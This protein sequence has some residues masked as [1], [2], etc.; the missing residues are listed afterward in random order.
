[1]SEFKLISPMLDNFAMGDSISE[2]DGVCCCP[3]M[4]N[5]SDKRYIVK[6]VSTPASQSQLEALLLSGAYADNDAANE[7]F[8]AITDGIAEEAQILEKLSQ[9]EGFLPF[10]SWQ[11]VPKE[12]GTGYDLYLLSQ[13][14]RTLQ[15]HFKRSGMT[16]L[17]ALNLGLDLCAALAVCRRLGYLYVDLKPENIYLT[18]DN[19]YRI[20]DLGFIK[21]DSLKYASLPDRYR[22]AYT[23]PEITDAFSALNTTMDTYALGL[24]LYQAFNDSSLPLMSK[25]SDA[26][27][28]PS[29]AYADYEMSEIILKA[30]AQDPENRWQDP[31]QMG[32]ALI[33]YM[34]RNGAHD[35]PII[36]QATAEETDCVED[37][38]LFEGSTDMGSIAISDENVA[39]V[40]NTEILVTEDDIYTQD[41]DGN[42]TF[43]THDSDDETAPDDNDVVEDYEQVT[44]EVNKMLNHADELIAH[45]APDPVIQPDPIEVALPES[46]DEENSD[47]DT[48]ADGDEP[49]SESGDESAIEQ[50]DEDCAPDNTEEEEKSVSECEDQQDDVDEDVPATD[51]EVG[52]GDADHEIDEAETNKKKHTAKIWTR[53]IL[54]IVL[55][56][57][58]I[59]AGIFFYMNYYLQPIE[60]IVLQDVEHGTLTVC[61]TSDIDESKLSVVCLDMYGN[62]LTAPV[63]D[64]KAVFTGLAPNSA[65][66]VKININGF[67][68]LTGDTWTSF[69]TPEETN[70]VQFQAVTGAE[71]G[72]VIL[73]FTVEGP[74]ANQWSVRYAAPNEEEKEVAF[75][76]HIATINGLTVGNEYTFTLVPGT[77]L[78]LVGTS[79]ITHTASNVIKAEGL[80]ITGCIDGKLTAKWSAPNDATVDSWTVRCY[81]DKNYDQT[82]VV[83]QPSATFEGV[84]ASVDHTVEVTA[85]AMSISERAFA[86]A[87]AITVTQFTLD[88]AN[89]N[90]LS[91]AWTA[92]AE[93]NWNLLCSIN[94]AVNQEISC[95]TETKASIRDIIPGSQ[96]K[97]T[98][99]ATDGTPVLGGEMVYQVPEAPS[100]SGYGVTA[101]QIQFKMCKTPAHKN[102][103]R[104]DLRSS[105]Y[106]TEF[107]IGK[108]ASFLAK[109]QHE[110][111]VSSDKVVTLYVIRDSAGTIISAAST[112]AKWSSMWSRNYG[113]FDIPALPGS[114]GEYTVS[115]YFDGALAH[116]QNF[117]MV[118]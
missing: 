109:M 5:D 104:Y 59:G 9:L 43:I 85:V 40:E 71:N 117:T 110:Y 56:L 3:A 10:E 20:G 19:E 95:G 108:K 28:L 64:G 55:A 52:V 100:F 47:P 107:K 57:V 32:Q 66:T 68:R 4:E 42:L 16:H 30:C 87:N 24:I 75:T 88:T 39:P 115:V 27:V 112:T 22:S 96:Y 118:S 106:T 31:I 105:D 14:R 101:E 83:N 49:D 12:D 63:K 34:Q 46:C 65:Y 53:N 94:G 51:S 36:P 38:G 23:P 99:Q 11:T 92:N 77:E 102:W 78:L 76:G 54:L 80:A 45:S 60:S 29:P 111:D 62:P 86:P 2:H 70:I 91:L 97:F 17:G 98:I 67:H 93:K 116:T 41:E 37:T 18:D 1:M 33:G 73:G 13:Y 26:P 48:Q 113:E 61:V 81:N 7:Y 84:D 58:A 44:E 82:I 50:E 8:R 74:D 21:L 90:Q 79:T 69:T 15:K 114:V 103:D 35:T 89:A 6:I 72:S 25:D